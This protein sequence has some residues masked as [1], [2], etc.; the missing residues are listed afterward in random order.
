[1]NLRTA[2]PLAIAVALTLGT[3]AAADPWIHVR[4]DGADPDDRVRL[5][6]PVGMVRSMLQ[7]VET[8]DVHDGKIRIDDADFDDVDLRAMLEAVRDADDAEFIRIRDDDSDIRVAK[9]RG[10]LLVHVDPREGGDERVRIRVPIE[11]VEA[12]LDSSQETGEL[13]IAAAVDVL[14]T[15]TGDLVVVEDG[16]QSVRIWIDR[17][18]EIAD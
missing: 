3:A 8:D 16:E 9:D 6:F 1:M 12:L 5:S 2:F 18:S 11:V 17:S 10:Q 13:D 14:A 7:G 15:M 4:V